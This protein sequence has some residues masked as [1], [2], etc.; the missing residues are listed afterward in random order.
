L[1]K[2]CVATTEDLRVVVLAATQT[3][4]YQCRF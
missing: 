1:I 2:L 4:Q 3:L